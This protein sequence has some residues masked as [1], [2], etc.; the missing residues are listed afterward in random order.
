[1]QIKLLINFLDLSWWIKLPVLLNFAQHLIIFYE[2]HFFV[3]S[4]G[5][6][7]FLL[8]KLKVL[9]LIRNIILLLEGLLEWYF[10]KWTTFATAVVIISGKQSTYFCYICVIK[11][12]VINIAGIFS[13]KEQEREMKTLKSENEEIG[14]EIKK[15]K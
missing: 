1:M 13:C 8:I 3:E 9:L 5:P 2:K 12:K 6:D 14:K 15:M 4:V 10:S 11:C 7:K